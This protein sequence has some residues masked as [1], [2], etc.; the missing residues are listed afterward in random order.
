M[1]DLIMVVPSRGRPTAVTEL[2]EAFNA[3]CTEDTQIVLALDRDD[4][5][6]AAYY[7][8]MTGDT[9]VSTIIEQDTG[10]MV[11]ALNLAAA[12]V[13]EQGTF[14]IGF[15]GDDHRPRT[16][17]WDKAYLDELR[18]IG[19]GIVYGD[20]GF[21]HINLPTQVAMTCDIVQALGYMAPPRLTHMYVDNFWRDLGEHA[22]CIS[23]LPDIVIEHVHPLAGK[24]E[25]DD[26]Y[27]RVNAA[28]MF[29]RDSRAYQS[30]LHTRAHTDVQAVRA[31]RQ[32]SRQAKS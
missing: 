8:T 27:R 13:V 28:E 3:T 18:R 16:E 14:A 22:D 1:S 6:R 15:M 11:S 26:G 25:W 7:R 24:A 2:A 30:Y 10:T 23:Y 12:H 31:L 32:A 19:T 29:D 21:Q 9:R 20:D 17:G 4:P 5:H